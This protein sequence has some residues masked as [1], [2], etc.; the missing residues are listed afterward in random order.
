MFERLY[1]LH[2]LGGLSAF[3]VL[4]CQHAIQHQQTINMITATNFHD[5]KCCPVFFTARLCVKHGADRS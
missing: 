2:M 5:L 1:V 3:R 4:L